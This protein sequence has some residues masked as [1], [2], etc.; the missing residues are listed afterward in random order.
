MAAGLPLMVITALALIILGNWMFSGPGKKR[1][2]SILGSVILL[3][4]GA[5]WYILLL[6]SAVTD[7]GAIAMGIAFLIA[8]ATFFVPVVWRWSIERK[9]NT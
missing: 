6:N 3:S 5:C 4:L 1:G 7:T 8:I 2:R 9:E